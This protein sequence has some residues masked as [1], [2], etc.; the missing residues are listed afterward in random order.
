MQPTTNYN[1]ET[2]IAECVKGSAKAQ[3]TLFDC[4]Y[5]K[6]Y[7]IALRYSK[8]TFEA[9]DI[10]QETFIQVFKNIANFKKDCPLEFWIRK[11]VV[12]T[13]LKANRRKLDKM[14]ME[15][16]TEM[17]DEPFD[18]STIN[19]YNFQ[20]L[21]RIIQQLPPGFQMVFNLYAIE[22]YQHREIAE[23]LGI[24]EG[25]SKSQ[26]ARARVQIQEMLEREQSKVNVRAV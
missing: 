12:N 15:D 8:T 25:T 11:I 7:V 21:I 18:N 2:L 20:E 13:A 16:I 22:G 24:S 17:V 3:R 9:E 23:M 19:N 26:Y 14:F 1:E 6:M 5:R 10:L 4:F